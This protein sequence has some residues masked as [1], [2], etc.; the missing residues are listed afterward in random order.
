[1][2]NIFE[3]PVF[4]GED[5]VKSYTK[6]DMLADDIFNAINSNRYSRDDPTNA[7][8]V[9]Q[10]FFNPILNNKSIKLFG[11]WGGSKES[12]D[13]KADEADI[14]TLD[15]LSKLK[16]NING[17]DFNFLEISLLFCDAHHIICNGKSLKE[18]QTYYESLE[19]LVNERNLKILKLSELLNLRDVD[20]FSKIKRILNDPY[21]R[22]QT[23]LLFENLDYASKIIKATKKHS[24]FSRQYHPSE[25]KYLAKLYVEMEINFL[26]QIYYQDYQKLFGMEDPKNKGG[27]VYFSLSNPEIQKPIAEVAE[28]PMLFF[29]AREGHHGE[30]PW[31]R[32]KNEQK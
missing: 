29:W 3:I 20:D 21:S 15:Y 10:N 6:R 17:K 32:S 30:V 8:S 27:L 25:L 23:N 12:E 9:K 13:N 1:M 14:Q 31:Y 2:R 7:L 16:S 24:D 19:N 26:R 11:L 4:H 5:G 28:V 22:K 18:V